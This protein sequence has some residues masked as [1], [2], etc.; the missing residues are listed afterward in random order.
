MGGILSFL[1]I[2]ILVV[3]LLKITEMIVDLEKTKIEG[4]SGKKKKEYDIDNLSKK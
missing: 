4:E 2:C 3:G 1:M